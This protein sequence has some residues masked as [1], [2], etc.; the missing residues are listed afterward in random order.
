MDE[1][2]ARAEKME[3]KAKTEVNQEMEQ[4]RRKRWE[5]S[6]RLEELKSKTDKAW[7]DLKSGID[8]AVKDLEK[9]FDEAISRF[10]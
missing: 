6:K 2:K 8:A 5:V 10:K 1:L 9:A 7:E 4:L 3:K